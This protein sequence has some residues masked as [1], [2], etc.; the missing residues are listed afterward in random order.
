[1]SRLPK[2]EHSLRRD[3][4]L[5]VA[6]A[7]IAFVVNQ[8]GAILIRSLRSTP[9]SVPAQLAAIRREATQSGLYPVIR[10]AHLH[11]DGT[12]S[13]VV[14]S[15]FGY[16][17]PGDNAAQPHSDA[18]TIYDLRGEN[19]GTRLVRRFAFTPAGVGGA[20][21]TPSW[22][23]RQLAV[24]DIA[25]DGRSELVGGWSEDRAD[26]SD[27]RPFVVAW[28][29][30]SRRYAIQALLAHPVPFVQVPGLS[31]RNREERT[32]YR[33]GTTMTDRATGTAFKAYGTASFAVQSASVVPGQRFSPALLIT[34]EGAETQ[35][36]LIREVQRHRLAV[37][38][39]EFSLDARSAPVRSSFC[40]A[41]T[42]QSNGFPESGS[43][44]ILHL[45]HDLSRISPEGLECPR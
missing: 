20:V 8:Y 38:L 28:D 19:G 6:G 2:P 36:H 5:L 33:S 21:D 45:A 27:V 29:P 41:G 43:P 13:V 11:G 25:D 37:E 34:V 16:T 42:T 15:I 44:V 40:G 23:L 3:V 14:E 1:M 30:A 9:P 31:E 10:R 39:D 24:A 7:V 12:E 35:T 4:S 26:D 32:L 22:R 17:L 18:L